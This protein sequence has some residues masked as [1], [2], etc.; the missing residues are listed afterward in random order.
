MG[1]ERKGVLLI[2]AAII[3]VI[4]PLGL[5]KNTGKLPDPDLWKDKDTGK[6]ENPCALR[7]RHP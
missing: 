3:D 6:T 1:T 5:C 4:L 7:E 2:G